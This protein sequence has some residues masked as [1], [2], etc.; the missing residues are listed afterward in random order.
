MYRSA[1]EMMFS[2]E[3]LRDVESEAEA[4]MSQSAEGGSDVAAPSPPLSPSTT[5][6]G[7]RPPPRAP[8]LV[9]RFDIEPDSDFSA[10]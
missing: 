1:Q 2:Y 6:A 3:S 9:E 10:K 5:G 7:Q 8:G 4:A